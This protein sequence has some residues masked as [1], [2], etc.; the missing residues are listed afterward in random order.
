[1]KTD[2]SYAPVYSD[3]AEYTGA[4][5]LKLLTNCK[6]QRKSKIFFKKVLTNEKQ[7]L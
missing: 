5:F 2:K 7:R 1:M 4:V 3:S 6:S